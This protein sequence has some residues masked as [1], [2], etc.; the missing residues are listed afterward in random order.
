MISKLKKCLLLLLLLSPL[1]AFADVGNSL[2][3]FQ[4][5]AN[6]FSK[7]LL[8]TTFGSIG[9]LLHGSGNQII[10]ILLGV[11]NVVWI[12]AIGIA[13]LYIVWDCVITAAQSGEMMAGRGKKTV[14]MILKIVLGF[15]LVVPSKST[16]YSLAQNGVI[17]V[18]LQ[19]V[20]FADQISDKLYN[21][22]KVG[23]EVFTTKPSLTTDLVDLMPRVRDILQ[24][25]I[26]M[27]K[28]QDVLTKQQN[29]DKKVLADAGLPS[30]DNPITNSVMGWSTAQ[31]GPYGSW[32][33]FGSRNPD[34]KPSDPSSP[35]YRDECGKI[36][37]DT[38]FI[39]SG[40]T[41]SDKKLLS[42]YQLAA[43]KELV[44][45]LFPFARA[46]TELPPDDDLNG[47]IRE[48]VAAS[49]ATLMST[50]GLSFATIIDPGRKQLE[51]LDD[52]DLRATL[53]RLKDRGWMFTPMMVIYPGLYKSDNAALLA[54]FPVAQVTEWILNRSIPATD[55]FKDL[56]ESSRNEL[57]RYVWNAEYD[58][59]AALA[60]AQLRAMNNRTWGSIDFEPI[61][62][63]D[64]KSPD[65]MVDSVETMFVGLKATMRAGGSL[66][67]GMLD[68]PKGTCEIFKGMGDFFG[69]DTSALDNCV[70]GINDA[71]DSLRDSIEGGAGELDGVISS[72]RSTMDYA[73][74]GGMTQELIDLTK[75]IGPLGPIFASI[76]TAMVGKSMETFQDQ[77][78]N[79]D[80]NALVSAIKVG[81]QMM[82]SSIESVFQSGH[83]IYV[84]TVTTGIIGA[85][86][87]SIPGA[88]GLIKA[89][90]NFSNQAI[91]GFT[92]FH[93]G[94]ALMIFSS[95]LLLY[96]MVP[97]G[98]VLAF[99]AICLQWIGMVLVSIM[100]APIFCFNLIRADNDG[101]IG[102]KGEI[103]IVDL[104]RTAITPALLTIGAVI[105]LI[106]FNIG[107]LIMTSVITE[108]IP[109]LT[110]AYNHPYLVPVTLGVML[111]MFAFVL[112]FMA[113]TLSSA[114]TADLVN[115]VGAAIG[116]GMQQMKDQTPG[117]ELKHLV[118]GAGSTTGS[119][120]KNVTSSGTG[121]MGKGG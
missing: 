35:E 64:R 108:F 78:F 112:T 48:V 60:Q 10:G 101:M 5:P 51:E 30:P 17:W 42:A 15:C 38:A 11:F 59:A 45:N 106:L 68:I 8:N 81:G 89:G 55:I 4:V 23:G 25:E 99:S 73:K 24:M 98:F 43:T 83:L 119:A 95:G 84:S 77:M 49:A 7:M 100:A 90:A 32:I 97:L 19:G 71:Q 1:A 79:P 46:I 36:V 21:Y 70:K 57:G 31:H 29:S 41:D 53:A 114:C 91:T 85:I 47:K 76:M 116:H 103:F 92:I 115:H 80:Y 67:N 75:N 18:V 74:K 113:Q 87:G 110:K 40:L 12:S 50:S 14:F 66:V 16:G 20:G 2:N 22:L 82:V 109:V 63:G 104:I 102:H 58:N 118:Q 44:L 6:D 52:K 3:L 39:K 62:T 33:T 72:L 34:Y 117:Q 111:M 94:L 61:Y 88:G 27:L 93:I 26:C 121:M 13:V 96:I 120:I 86:G 65:G 54:F 69:G 28:T 107:F 9:G 37:V 56:N 105:F